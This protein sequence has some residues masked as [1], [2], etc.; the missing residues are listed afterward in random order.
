M[1]DIIKAIDEICNDEVIKAV[2]SNKKNKEFKYNKVTFQLK[3]KNNKQYP[4]DSVR[5]L[6]C[7]R[8]ACTKIRSRTPECL[9]LYGRHPYA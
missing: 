7:T 4:A 6:D 1:E 8:T 5:R 2:I 9:R 3:E